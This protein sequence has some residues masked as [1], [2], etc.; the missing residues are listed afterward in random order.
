M[1]IDFSRNYPIISHQLQDK[2]LKCKLGLIGCGLGSNIASLA[3]RVGFTNFIIAD[4]DK[5][6]DTN[7]NRQVFNASEVGEL[8]STATSKHISLI[9]KLANVEAIDHYITNSFDIEEFV[10]KSDFIINTADFQK[11]FYEIIRVGINNNKIVITPFNVGYGSAMAVFK[12]KNQIV[13]VEELSNN[14][15]NDTTHFMNL[16]KKSVNYKLPKYFEPIFLEMV[17]NYNNP[18][19]QI[20]LAANITSSLVV[21]TILSILNNEKISTYPEI[22]ALDPKI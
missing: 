3:A 7:L 12:E 20:G 14:S 17:K 19:P 10:N 9:N 5:V 11:G 18:I 16:L 21:T 1:N 15:E 8:K 22:I 2:L 13:I 6:E 4:G